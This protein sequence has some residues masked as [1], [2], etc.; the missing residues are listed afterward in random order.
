MKVLALSFS[1]R[2][3][4]NTVQLLET[5]LGAAAEA[6]AETELWKLAG[7]TV[8]PCD[9]CNA[10]R[11]TAVCHIDDD[12]NGLY[13]RLL[14][15]DAI[16]FGTPVYFYNVTGPGK[17]VIDRTFALNRP[18]RNLAN[19]VG[20][21]V[22]VAGSLGLADAV[23]DLYFYMVTRQMLPAMFVAAYAGARGDVRNLPKC[24]ASAAD[25]GRQVV[26]MAAQGFAYP[27]DIVPPHFAYGTHTR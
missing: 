15:A 26:A 14:E 23:K 7:K 5:V 8:L 1:P 4:G 24:R 21:V 6:G 17:T 13:P 11:K 16:V 18:G 25:L 27:S 22:C 20:G 19:K 12:M 9:G 10:C 3:A 2:P